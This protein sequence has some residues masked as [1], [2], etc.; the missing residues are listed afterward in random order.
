[1]LEIQQF[2]YFYEQ[3]FQNRDWSYTY[4]QELVY[5]ILRVSQQLQPWWTVGNFVDMSSKFNVHRICTQV[6]DSSQ[7]K[8]HNNNNN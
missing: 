6:T 5:E 8:I 7:N 2:S 4:L 1:M 3:I